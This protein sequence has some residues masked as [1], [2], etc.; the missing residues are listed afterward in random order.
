MNSWMSPDRSRIVANTSLP[1]SR[2]NMIRPATATASSVSVPG[3]SSPHPARTWL[4]VWVRSNRYGYGLPP[5]SRIVV[6]L[7]QASGLL[8]GEPAAGERSVGRSR[9]VGARLGCIGIWTHGDPTVSK[10]P[11]KVCVDCP[12]EA[13]NARVSPDSGART[14]QLHSVRA[15]SILGLAVLS[16]VAVS[17]P[18][19]AQ[20]AP[21]VVNTPAS[22][23]RQA[24]STTP[25]ATDVVSVFNSG[26]LR[27]DTINRSIS[28]ARQ[29]GAAVAFGRSAS[30]G[31]IGLYRGAA[32]VQL[33]P[34]GFAVPMGDHRGAAGIRG[35]R[36]G[37]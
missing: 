13:S 2:S 21:G 29:A 15:R 3:S 14:V 22:A 31:M 33:P 20:G 26:P 11:H 25:L 23:S 36:D 18:V 19:M 16:A 8:G 4:T 7:R 30:V 9:V 5:A 37:P 12:T 35:Q 32:P 6:D 1:E 27:P 28:A 34:A 10:L 24:V 17:I